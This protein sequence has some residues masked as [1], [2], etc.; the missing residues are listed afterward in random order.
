MRLR[1]VLGVVGRL[2]LLFSP[3]FGVPFLLALAQARYAGAGGF[4]VGGL[5]AAGCGAA[6]SR[7]A[8]RPS[9]LHRNEA[10]AVVASTWLLV[11][12]FAALP[13][14]V[15][16]LSLPDA[17]FESMSGFT[18]TGATVLTDFSLYDDAFY[19][20]RA[21]TQWFGGVGVIALFVVVLPQLGI[22]GR[23]L[24]FA[25]ASGA[26]GEGVSP[27]IR[28][29]AQKVWLLY[30]ALTALCM[31]LLMA[32]GMTF[33]EG[34]VHAMATLAAGG[35]SPNGASVAG[36]QN[37]GAEWVLVV[38]MFLGGASFPLQLKV[39][40]QGL[41]VLRDDDEFVAYLG[42]TVA[43]ALALAF[44]VAG[45]PPG[46]EH[47][48]AGFFQSASIISSTG[49]ASVD[50]NLWGDPARAVIL[51]L[52]VVGGCAGSAAGGAKVVRHL[53]VG[54]AILREVRQ[55]LHPRAVIPLRY[56]DQPIADKVLRAVVA[57]VTLYVG[58]VFVVGCVLV[59]LGSDPITAF[60]AAMACT[61]NI[62]PGF[63]LVGPM[64]NYAGFS[65]AGTILLTAA[66]W[67]GRLE[68]FTVL[69]LLHPEAWRDTRFD[70]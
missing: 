20:W 5:L 28:E 16:G 3:A 54:R 41:R 9:V 4:F 26:P 64:G 45:G 47:L 66:M 69:A 37:P 59:F 2:V 49:F 44:L 40:T 8:P 50:Y 61:G 13:F 38:F 46:E 27:S 48:R 30:G 57:L 33:Y 56:K 12:V 58:I 23:Q 1:T 43:G 65:D 22:A 7:G 52:M 42:F 14:L 10:M 31:G 17:L 18:T 29:S 21:M 11:S 25:E 39:G 62:G 34:V 60:S 68:I 35:F 24:F 63:D 36:Y 15:Y 53:I 51:I 32:C 67:L 19:L 55:V 70:L 6:I